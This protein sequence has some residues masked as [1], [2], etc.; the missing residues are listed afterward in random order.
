MCTRVCKQDMV[1]K[2]DPFGK[3]ILSRT[4]EPEKAGTCARDRRARGGGGGGGG[5]A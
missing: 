5:H 4:E 2:Q 3:Y 1:L